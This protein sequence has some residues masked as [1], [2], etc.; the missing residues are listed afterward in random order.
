MQALKTE[1]LDP[2]SFDAVVV[3][4]SGGKDSIAAA[5]YCL[6]LGIPK[7]KLELWH[8]DIDGREEGQDFM[9]W[10]VTASYVRAFGQ[11]IGLPVYFSWR[12]GGFLREMLKKDCP[13][14]RVHFETPEG[15][16]TGGGSWKQLANGR[17][18]DTRTGKDWKHIGTR[19]QFPQVSPNLST[20]WCSAALK[21]DVC[22]LAIRGQERFNGKRVLIVSGERAQESTARAKYAELELHKTS[23]NTRTVYQWRP[24]HKWTEAQVWAI[25]KRHGIQPHPAYQLGWGRVSCALCIFGGANQWASAKALFPERV[26]R[27][28]G[29][30]KAFGKTIDRDGQNA[31]QK[32]ARGTAYAGCSNPE[33]VS[34]AKAHAFTSHQIVV[35]PAK[36]ELPA[37]AFSGGTCGPE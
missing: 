7:S 26:E 14:A 9:D 13:T 23:C 20:R 11:A 31:L 25:M 34:R 17:Y 1:N 8:H 24:V 37:G 36:W 16:S 21:I 27:V 19:Q 22:A 10:P 15:L 6:E 2:N 35:D 30:E 5:L 28:A 33:L 3:A 18:I 29:F 4:C 12:E 32:A